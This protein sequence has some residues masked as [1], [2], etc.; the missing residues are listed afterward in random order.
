MRDPNPMFA[1]AVVLA[2]LL[3]P[4]GP[5]RGETPHDLLRHFED[6][7][8]KDDPTFK[9]NPG[10]GESF[11]RTE[12]PTPTPAPARASACAG[13]HSADPRQPGRTRA[14][15]QIKPLAPVSNGERFTDRVKVE[16][17]F[18]RNCGDGLGRDCTAAEKADFIAWLANLK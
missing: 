17:W 4:I 12:H 5:A 11:Y 13:C 7:A 6:V 9:G 3:L 1:I 14:N 16:K 15:K 10:R 18:A 8:R 2:S